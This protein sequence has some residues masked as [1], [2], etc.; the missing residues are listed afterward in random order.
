MIEAGAMLRANDISRR[1]DFRP[2]FAGAAGRARPPRRCQPVLVIGVGNAER[3]DDA[4][5]RVAARLVRARA[6]AGV[7]VIESC[8]EPASLLDAWRGARR[9][10][11]V[12]AVQSG[13]ARGAIHRFDA[14]AGALP[15]RF[16][17]CSTHGLGVAEA[18]E[19][20]RALRCLPPRLVV[21][22]IEAARF[23]AGETPSRVLVRAAAEA[24]RRVREEIGRGCEAPADM[25]DPH[26]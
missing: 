8:G 23:G 9:V 2:G 3:G 24:A 10:F 25:G 5:G 19:L 7:R 20:A 22:G 4:I 11:L 6:P 15:A 18:V 16:F 21:Y 26:A 13:A 12:D 1:F 17:R 14:G